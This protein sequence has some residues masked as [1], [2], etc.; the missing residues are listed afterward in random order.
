MKQCICTW[1]DNLS[2]FQKLT[3]I[4]T[5][6]IYHRAWMWGITQSLIEYKR[7]YFS[8]PRAQKVTDIEGEYKHDYQ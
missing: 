1:N 3:M 4:Y 7:N 8:N 5:M 2:I 6:A